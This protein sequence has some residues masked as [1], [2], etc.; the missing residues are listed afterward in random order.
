MADDPAYKIDARG[1]FYQRVRPGKRTPVSG[2][3]QLGQVLT[4][5]QHPRVA[6]WIRVQ[7]QR[8]T[9]PPLVREITILAADL[10]DERGAGPGPEAEVSPQRAQ[11]V[12]TYPG[13]L[14]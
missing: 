5:T 12:E 4:I 8:N 6:G 3:R 13:W 2:Y 14:T 9:T 7:L 11:Q 1:G 10:V